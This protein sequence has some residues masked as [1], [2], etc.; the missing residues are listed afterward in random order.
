MIIRDQAIIRGNV[1]I[2]RWASPALLEKTMIRIVLFTLLTYGVNSAV[3]QSQSIKTLQYT[4]GDQQGVHSFKT[5]GFLTRSVLWLAGHGEFK[6]AIRTLKNFQ[7]I[8]VPKAAFEKQKV[9]VHGFQKIVQRDAFE[10]VASVRD[11]AELVTVY[12]QDIEGSQ[13]NRYL[14][15]IDNATEFVAVEIK[16][17]IDTTLINNSSLS[18]SNN[19]KTQ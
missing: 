19:C 5:S 15:L 1:R 6:S 10:E 14:I 18:L 3:A 2:D 12:L 8:I 13:L 17:Y 4:F 7:V 9:T 11:E 16:G